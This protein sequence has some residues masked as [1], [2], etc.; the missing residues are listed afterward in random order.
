[1]NAWTFYVFAVPLTVAAPA[2]VTAR[3][4]ARRELQEDTVLHREPL[5]GRDVELRWRGDDYGAT[6]PRRGRRLQVRR[7]IE[8][9]WTEWQDA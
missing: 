4:W 5:S 7:R 9:A 8:C 1:M 6:G 2:W 3:D